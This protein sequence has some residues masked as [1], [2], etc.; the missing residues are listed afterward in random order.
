MVQGNFGMFV[1]FQ[2]FTLKQNRNVVGE[3]L[4]GLFLQL[5]VPKELLNT[6]GIFM[7]HFLGAFDD[8]RLDSILFSERLGN[9]LHSGIFFASLDLL[10]VMAILLGDLGKFNRLFL[11]HLFQWFLHLGFFALRLRHTSLL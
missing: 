5:W 9:R 11:K 8:F 4:F 6:M 1:H 7:M 10:I 2:C 3:K